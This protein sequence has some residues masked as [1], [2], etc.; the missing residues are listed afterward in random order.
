MITRPPISLLDD[1]LNN[2]CGKEPDRQRKEQQCRHAKFETR[3]IVLGLES[4]FLRMPYKSWL[5][6]PTL[7]QP[8]VMR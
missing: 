2:Q 5:L 6:N 8:V 7:L 3:G 1:P 4:T